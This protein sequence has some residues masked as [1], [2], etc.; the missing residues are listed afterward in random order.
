ML[1]ILCILKALEVIG[2]SSTFNFPN[3]TFPASSVASCSIRGDTIRHGPHHGAQKSTTNSGY[4]LIASAKLVSDSVMGAAT[5]A[6][7]LCPLL[8]P[9]LLLFLIKSFI[10]LV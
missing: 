1:G 7:L 10:F 2:F 6:L 5:T 4:L 9:P 8:P 3:T